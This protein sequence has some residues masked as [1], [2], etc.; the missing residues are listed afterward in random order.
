MVDEGVAV[1]LEAVHG[2]VAVYFLLAHRVVAVPLHEQLDTPV[3]ERRVHVLVHHVGPFPRKV[4]IARHHIEIRAREVALILVGRL[5]HAR[6]AAS[7][8]LHGVS[9]GGD[10]VFESDCRRTVHLAERIVALGH[11]GRAFRR[12]QMVQIHIRRHCGASAPPGF[13][14]RMLAVE[15]FEARGVEGDVGVHVPPAVAFGIDVRH[16]EIVWEGAVAGDEAESGHAVVYG[17][18]EFAFLFAVKA[19]V[20]ARGRFGMRGRAAYS[21]CRQRNCDV[22]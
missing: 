3:V 11:V 22:A 7:L 19:V 8:P 16:P 6:C 5:E 4:L 21:S 10:A 15:A 9:H 18:L 12:I 20:V 2:V 1:V 14:K 13:R 17:R